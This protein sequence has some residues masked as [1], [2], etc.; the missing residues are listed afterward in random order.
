M[1]FFEIFK[2]PYMNA[3][4]GLDLG[5]SGESLDVDEGQGDVVD[6]DGEGSGEVNSQTNEK[7]KQDRDTNEQFKAARVAAEREMRALEER[8]NNFARMYGY[9]S[10][11]E[12]EY[13]AQLQQYTNQGYSDAEAERL[14]RLEVIEQRAM[15]RE[16]NARIAEEKAALKTK[17][18]FSELEPDI[19]K[20]LAVNPSLNVESVY[21]YIRGEKMEELLAKETAATKQKTLNNIN[22]KQHL[23]TEGDGAGDTDSVNI[24]AETLQMYLDMGMNKKDAVAHYKKLYK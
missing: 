19:D 8:Q 18:Y 14:A 12:M 21:K 3:D 24:P 20:V 4:D 5:G 13:A 11:E 1:K 6:S 7:P 2:T 9:N 10:F 17:K 22:S 16:N 23:N 15:L